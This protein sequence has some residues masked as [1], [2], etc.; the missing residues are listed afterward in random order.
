MNILFF[1]DEQSD[2][3]IH[4]YAI[5]RDDFERDLPVMRC[6]TL[7]P[8]VGL[9]LSCHIA[10]C[11]A[12]LTLVTADDLTA[13]GIREGGLLVTFVARAHE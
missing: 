11:T 12:A 4:Y 5:P 6:V 2:D 10:P 3:H 8:C 7:W 9:L 13:R 1:A